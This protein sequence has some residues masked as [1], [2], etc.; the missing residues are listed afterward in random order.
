MASVDPAWKVRTRP[1]PFYLRGGCIFAANCNFLHTT[2]TAVKTLDSDYDSDSSFQSFKSPASSH[3]PTPVKQ[4][5]KSMTVRVESP[6]AS[7]RLPPR[8][9]QMSRLLS[10]LTDVIGEDEDDEEDGSNSG[11]EEGEEQYMD[12]MTLVEP[13]TGWSGGLPTLVHGADSNFFAQVTETMAEMMR[14]TEGDDNDDDIPAPDQ[15]DDDPYDFTDS[16]F[17]SHSDY[18]RNGS[19]SPQSPSHSRSHSFSHSPTS[20]SNSSNSS[21][22]ILDNNTLRLPINETHDTPSIHTTY[23]SPDPVQILEM[24]QIPDNHN[25]LLSPVDLS[26]LHLHNFSSLDQLVDHD[27]SSDSSREWKDTSSVDSGFVDSTRPP[28]KSPTT[29]TFG[30]LHSP[31]GSPSARVLSPRIG[32][33]LGRSPSSPLP[34]L[35][36]TSEQELAALEDDLDSP[37]THQRTALVHW[38]SPVAASV[39]APTTL[40]IS[41]TEEAR[42][43]LPSSPSST[44]YS[45]FSDEEGEILE[46]DRREED[47]YD[48]VDSSDSDADSQLGDDIHESYGHTDIWQ[49]GEST[50][51]YVGQQQQRVESVPEAYDEMSFE[52]HS[53]EE[54]GSAQYDDR[55]EEHHIPAAQPVESVPEVCDENSFEA[56]SYEEEDSGQYDDGE[57]DDQLL[58]PDIWAAG[59]AGSVYIGSHGSLH[60]SPQFSPLIEIRAELDRQKSQPLVVPTP[61]GDYSLGW[62]DAS[63]SSPPLHSTLSRQSPG[64]DPADESFSCKEMETHTPEGDDSLSSLPLHPTPP[65]PGLD[66][67]D[68]SS[69]SSQQTETHTPECDDSLGWDDTSPSSTP[70]HR[71]LPGHSPDLDSG[72]DSISSTEMGDLSGSDITGALVQDYVTAAEFPS[73]A[74]LEATMDDTD[75]FDDFGSDDQDTRQLDPTDDSTAFLAYLEREENTQA[76]DGDT[77]YSLYDSY[78]VEPSPKMATTPFSDPSTPS[79]SLRERVFTPPPDNHPR[80][81]MPPVQSPAVPSSPP[82]SLGSAPLNGRFSPF[83]PAPRTPS[84]RSQSQQSQN[85]PVVSASTKVPFG[86]RAQHR[87]STSRSGSVS[88]TNRHRTLAHVTTSNLGPSDEPDHISSTPPSSAGSGGSALRPLRLSVLLHSHSNSISRSATA[89]SNMTSFNLSNHLQ[90]DIHEPV[91][92]A[93]VSTRTSLSINSSL[94]NA[95]LRSAPMHLSSLIYSQRSP[96]LLT[97][98]LNHLATFDSPISAPVSAPALSHWPTNV[99]HRTSS[100]YYGNHLRPSSRLSEPIYELDAEDEGDTHRH[101]IRDETIR[102]PVPGGPSPSQSPGPPPR[103]APVSRSASALRQPP[104]YN[105]IATPKPTLMFAIASDDVEQVRQ[106]L[107]SGDANPNDFVGPQSAL[108]FALSNDQLVNKLEIVKTLL[109]FGADPSG[110]KGAETDGVEADGAAGEAPESGQE[111]SEGEVSSHQSMKNLMDAMDPAT[112]YYVERAKAPQTRRTSALIH[113]SFFRPLTRVQYYLIGQDRALEE[114]FKLLSIHSR[115]ISV[116]PLVVMFSGPSGHGKS[117][118]A[119]KFGSLLDV[120]THTVNMVTLKSQDDLWESYSISP[121][122]EPSNCTLSEFLVNN[123][124]KRCVVVLDEIEKVGN[125]KV[126]WSLLMPWEH[127]RCSFE[128]RSRHVDVRNVIWLCTSN[129]GQEL[130]F[131]HWTSRETPEEVLSR[132]EFLDLVALLRPLVSEQLGASVL[133]RITSVLPFVPFTLHEKRAMSAEAIYQLGGEDA[134]ALSPQ[135]VERLIHTALGHYIPE[136][137]ARSLHR[138]ISNNLLDMI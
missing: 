127:G 129:I 57:E 97:D 137:G 125:E 68:E 76:Q 51:I 65:P 90:S 29:S 116:S 23:S 122:E 49:D 31:F 106:V 98:D 132:P 120:P 87:Y 81:G 86:F 66:S 108:A 30:L 69:F 34:E 8:E 79:S 73:V 109:A 75:R 9:P 119:R 61:E 74:S 39:G 113:R 11:D 100:S 131:D 33:F 133:S 95:P 72:N 130:V 89:P 117:L 24:P 14:V 121:A 17:S 44:D 54:E 10:A 135:Q 126:L 134:L 93:P 92:N 114:L 18:A 50:S 56:H 27:S 63:P 6:L 32:A 84:E 71:T 19:G 43:P 13:D 5:G 2:Q 67:A 118:L 20:S 107:E 99:H 94:S 38:A 58:Q 88:S 1:C 101:D 36:L 21:S 138:A 104:I 83:T 26:H 55:E 70:L 28:A 124:G 59:G 47:V 77:L 62:D 37:S 41:S 111:A 105:A 16:F 4:Y 46:V 103:T 48:D 123:E 64:L 40:D 128:A 22:P 7:V 45:D 60:N 115:K 91:L 25:D 96:S 80:Y 112:R 52:A 78:S 110:L 3:P 12:S 82:T 136:E 15:L 42:V 85:S 35:P 102:R 53:Y